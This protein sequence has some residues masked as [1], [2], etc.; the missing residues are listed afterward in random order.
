VSFVLLDMTPETFAKTKN[1][2]AKFVLVYEL[3]FQI[4][5]VDTDETPTS[6]I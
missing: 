3:G 6:I 2:T 4:Q 1:S 5:L